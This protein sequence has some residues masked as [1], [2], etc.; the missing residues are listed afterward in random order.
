MT[1]EPL[2]IVAHGKPVPQGSVRSLGTGRPSIHGNAERLLPWRDTIIIATQA[3]KRKA[4]W[5]RADGPVGIYGVFYFNRPKAHFTARGTLKPTAPK[6][7][8]TRVNGDLD[9]LARAVGDAL[10]A[11][12]A[13]RDDS[14]IV[15]WTVTKQFCETDPDSGL[16]HPGAV[17]RLVRLTETTMQPEATTPKRGTLHS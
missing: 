4:K 1:S 9:H 13:I 15:S 17:L 3:A 10:T 8:T 12:G 7:P 5:V 16:T 6:W 2:R 11:A 14:Q